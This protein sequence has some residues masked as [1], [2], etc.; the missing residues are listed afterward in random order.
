MKSK[1]FNLF[2]DLSHSLLLPEVQKTNY[3]KDLKK[4]LGIFVSQ[5]KREMLIKQKIDYIFLNFD[6][7]GYEV[8]VEEKINK[9]KLSKDKMACFPYKNE[10]INFFDAVFLAAEIITSDFLDKKKN[11]TS[12]FASIYFMILRKVYKIDESIIDNF[13]V[14]SKIPKKFVNIIY[15]DFVN[16]TAWSEIVKKHNFK[17]TD[18]V[19]DNT[20]SDFKRYVFNNSEYEIIVCYLKHKKIKA[21]ELL[22]N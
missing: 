14:M 12:E 8:I 13:Y 1:A 21:F 19:E 16:L 3:Y 9:I 5:E 17:V 10:D 18:G 22:K 6:I 4:R 2:Y 7:T 11:Y 15:D 20:N